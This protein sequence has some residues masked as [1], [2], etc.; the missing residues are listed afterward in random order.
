MDPLFFVRM[1]L[2]STVLAFSPTPSAAPT[3]GPAPVYT[4]YTVRAGDTLIG[5][6]TRFNTTTDAIL[7]ANGLK[8]PDQL[9]AGQQLKI[10]SALPTLPATTPTPP[11]A[12]SQ[13]YTVRAGDT[14]G[15]IATRFGL[16]ADDLAAA[17]GL[18]NQNTIAVGQVLIIPT[19]GPTPT[20]TKGPQGLEL[21]PPVPAQGQTFEIRVTARDATTATGSFLGQRLRF[22]R[23]KDYLY[24]LVGISRCA[25]R[26]N[27]PLSVTN[28]SADAREISAQV[29]VAPTNFPVENIILTP[30]MA[31]ALSDPTVERLENEKLIATVSQYS[32]VQNWTGTFSSPLAVKNYLSTT[33][34]QF[35]Q[36]RS[37]NNGPVGQCGHEGQDFAVGEGT[38]VMAPAPGR[39]V[40]AELQKVRGNVVFI[41]HG[42]GVFSGFYHLSKILV[43]PGQTVSVGDRLGLVGSTGFSSGA[44]LHWS[45]WVNGEYVDPIEW[46]ERVIP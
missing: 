7:L 10:P 35:G 22:V 5:I 23:T 29:T 37:Y 31:A 18:K 40:L 30:Q 13:T 24:A 12:G 8:N 15:S 38:P 26:G 4:T 3:P 25:S 6:A 1:V 32:P 16:T 11:G 33:S 46:T 2:L 44:H 19:R 14:L 36:R 45:L 17:N 21:V 39:V 42:Q 28:D 43:T 34:A 20:P 9:A 27:F 41:D